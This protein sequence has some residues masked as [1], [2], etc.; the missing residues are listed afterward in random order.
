MG[1]FAEVV[2]G[3]EGD[4]GLKNL[5]M[6]KIKLGDIEER[7][8][9]KESIYLEGEGSRWEGRRGINNEGTRCNCMMS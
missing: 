6:S 3:P 2:G 9:Q 1:G 7:I 5:C 4:D 8:F